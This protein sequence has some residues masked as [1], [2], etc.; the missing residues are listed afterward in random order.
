MSLVITPYS[1]GQDT[2]EGRRPGSERG[3]LQALLTENVSANNPE[4]DLRAAQTPQ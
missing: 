1:A 2:G 3:E 4:D